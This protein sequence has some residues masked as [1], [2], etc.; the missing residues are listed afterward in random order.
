M[1]GFIHHVNESRS[2]M[3]RR[4]GRSAGSGQVFRETLI[5]SKVR[6]SQNKRPQ[7]KNHFFPDHHISNSV[8]R[9][10]VKCLN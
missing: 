4:D 7:L 3:Q 6:A 10:I 1:C 8:S 5:V 2:A 9:M